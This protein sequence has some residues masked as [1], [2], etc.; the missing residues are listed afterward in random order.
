M[1]RRVFQF[2]FLGTDLVGAYH[3]TRNTRFRRIEILKRINIGYFVFK[4]YLVPLL[5]WL[6]IHDRNCR[7]GRPLPK[8]Q[9][10]VSETN[11]HQL[12]IR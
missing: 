10:E 9:Y 7:L 4:V 11:R 2:S 12:S 1:N 6:V 3:L 5:F 8:V